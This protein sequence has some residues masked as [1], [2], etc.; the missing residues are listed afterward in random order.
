MQSCFIGHRTIERTEELAL[1]LRETVLTLIINGVNTFVFGSKSQFNDLSWEIV[2]ELKKDFPFI[3][4]VY[5]RSAFQ[6]ISKEYEKY[7]LQ[8]YEETYFLPKLEKAGKY[9]Y[10]ER[11]Y[12]MIDKS[13][14]CIFYYNEKYALAKRSSGTKIAYEYA[15]RKKKQI[16]NLY[17]QYT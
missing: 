10:V 15:K 6:Y 11:N 2:T 9:S 14:Y 13:S 7:L 4:R 1:K 17:K 5:C 8:W 3:K 16:I 12:V